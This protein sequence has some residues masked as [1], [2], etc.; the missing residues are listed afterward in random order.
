MMP[1]SSSENSNC[2]SAPGFRAN[3]NS[4]SPLSSSVTKASVVKKSSDTTIPRVSIPAS[5]SVFISSLPNASL[6]TLPSIAVLA[7]YFVSAA[8]KFAG[9]PPGCAA[10]VG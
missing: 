9:A 2:V 1:R 7:P 6:P 5:S 4:R 10:I 3:E 8:R